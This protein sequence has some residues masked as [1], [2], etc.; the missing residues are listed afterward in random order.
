M[1]VSEG[2]GADSSKNLDKQK[3]YIPVYI[4]NHEYHN[5]RGGGVVGRQHLG[6][7]YSVLIA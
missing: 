5:P 4:A 7:E 6:T 2:E 3:K 1:K